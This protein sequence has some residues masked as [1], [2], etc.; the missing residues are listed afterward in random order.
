MGGSVRYFA[1]EKKNEEENGS[2][3]ALAPRTRVRRAHA[4]RVFV[5]SCNAVAPG[6]MS[7]RE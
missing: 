2:I 6:G 1:L 7:K 3:P 4:R 5:R